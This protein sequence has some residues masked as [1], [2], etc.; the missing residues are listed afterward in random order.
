MIIGRLIEN[1]P[2]CFADVFE[3]A[4][5]KITTRLPDLIEPQLENLSTDEFLSL[6]TLQF[7]KRQ[8]S[9]QAQS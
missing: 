6:M 7:T 3:E 5:W 1:W 8:Q 9:K 2:S 4:P